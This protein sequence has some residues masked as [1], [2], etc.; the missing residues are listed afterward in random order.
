MANF[1]GAKGVIKTILKPIYYRLPV[2]VCYGPS[3]SNTLK[4]LAESQTWSEDHLVEYQISKLKVML[5]HSAAHVPYYRRLF[6]HV[7]FDPERLRTLSDLSA[8]PLLEKDLIQSNP[9]DFLAENVRSSQR[10][11]FTTGG[12]MGKPLGLYNMRDSGGR[13]RAFIHAQWARVGFHLN[14]RRAML[15]GW[16]VRNKRHWTYEASERAYVFSNFHMT[17]ENVAEYARVMR[18]KLLPYLH[19]YPSAV[20]D[21]SRRLR[22]LGLEPPQ[23]RAVLAASENLYPGQREFIESFFNAR[24]FSWYGHTENVV[25]AGECEASNHYHVFPEYGVTEVVKEDGSAAANEGELGELVGTSLD[26]FAMPL[27]RYR[28]EDWAVIGPTSCTCGRNYKLLKETR[29]RWH[30]EMLVGKLDNLISV[31]AL[32]VHSDVFD[33][34]RQLQFYQRDKGKVELRIIRKPEYSERDSRRILAALNEKIGDTLE[35]SL[36]FPDEIPLMPR[37]KFRFVIRELPLPRAFVN[38][39]GVEASS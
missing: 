37:G 38:G 24:L 8:L 16:A 9:A 29:G 18:R 7:G 30:Q 6:H 36:S 35:L 14:D 19:S 28:T 13:E 33:N 3:F 27:I 4:L 39:G 17:P 31:T 15:R 32:N 1:A 5:R 21:F 11:Y 2:S 23:F 22:D 10:H 25:L 26:N 34:V 12:T 20:I